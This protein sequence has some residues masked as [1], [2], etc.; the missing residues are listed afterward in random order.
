MANRL[1]ATRRVLAAGFEGIGLGLLLGLAPLSVDLARLA[2]HAHLLRGEFPAARL[3]FSLPRIQEAAQE[4][5]FAA[6]V[7]VSDDE[8]T[9]ALLF[10]RREF[11]DAHVTL[12][13]RERPAL[14][15]ALLPFG[16]TKISAGVCTAPGG[17]ASREHAGVPQFSIQDKRTGVEMAARIRDAGLVPVWC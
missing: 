10:L 11:P 6:A 1:D 16:V 7:Q 4:P 17:Y 12:T 15:D 14:R 5:G 3:G 8:F 9:Q 2:R 13:T